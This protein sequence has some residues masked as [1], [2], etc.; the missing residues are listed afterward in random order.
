MR[1]WCQLGTI[2]APKTTIL[3]VLGRLGGLMGALERPGSL[4]V[5]SWGCLGRPGSLSVASWAVKATFYAA[6]GGEEAV[7]GHGRAF[8][9][10]GWPTP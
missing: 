2:L 4:S 9:G 6:G 5:A 10:A 1:F 8:P 3:L 7:H